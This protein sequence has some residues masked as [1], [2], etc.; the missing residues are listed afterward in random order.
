MKQMRTK[1]SFLFA[2]IHPR[3]VKNMLYFFKFKKKQYVYSGQIHA[4]SINLCVCF[5]KTY[6][7]L[8]VHCVCLI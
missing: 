4:F 1:V 5:I 7:S 2:E 6:A 8:V 3:I